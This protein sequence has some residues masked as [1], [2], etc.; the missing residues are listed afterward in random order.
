MTWS[1]H[2][3]SEYAGERHDHDLDY[4]EKHHRHHDL[5]REDER[6]KAD[7][8]HWQVALRELRADLEA[9]LERIRVLEAQTPEARQAEYEADIAMADGAESGYDE[10]WRDTLADYQVATGSADYDDEEGRP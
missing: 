8:D 1:D 5:E 3:H 10:S 4:A 7:L 6:L 2:T 9:A